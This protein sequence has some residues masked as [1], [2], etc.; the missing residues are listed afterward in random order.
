MLV[1]YLAR[2]VCC[3]MDEVRRHAVIVV[4][5]GE[6]VQNVFVSQRA[7]PENVATVLRMTSQR[8]SAHLD[9]RSTCFLSVSTMSYLRLSI[10]FVAAIASY[11]GRRQS[12]SNSSMASNEGISQ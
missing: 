9:R 6:S 7:C 5:I 4:W 10:L 1:V 3:R 11:L 8:A 2:C 12:L